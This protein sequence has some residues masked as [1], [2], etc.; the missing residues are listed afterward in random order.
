M[1]AINSTVC[2]KESHYL[3]ES[4]KET[5]LSVP[6]FSIKTSKYSQQTYLNEHVENTD[7]T[8]HFRRRK[9]SKNEPNYDDKFRYAES[10]E[11]NTKSVNEFDYVFELDEKD[12]TDSIDIVLDNHEKHKSKIEK[13]DTE[14]SVYLVKDKDLRMLTQNENL[15]YISKSESE[16]KPDSI[17]T[18]PEK[19]VI[20][21]DEEDIKLHLDKINHDLEASLNTFSENEHMNQTKREYVQKSKRKS[22]FLNG[23]DIDFMKFT[24]KTKFMGKWMEENKIQRSEDLRN[25]LVKDKV[26]HNVSSPDLEKNKSNIS[27][28]EKR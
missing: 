21:A 16:S 22:D 25:S 19:R 18:Y 3:N 23:D 9:R 5:T 14:E 24:N 4:H 13:Q 11:D 6:R 28:V 7:I 1:A 15:L 2:T 12:N 8:N 17:T 26:Q 20:N 10:Q 27:T